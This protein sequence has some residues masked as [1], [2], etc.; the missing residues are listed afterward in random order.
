MEQ[1]LQNIENSL[2]HIHP[3]PVCCW[4]LFCDC[5]VINL[6][7]SQPFEK[8][9]CFIYRG[10]CFYDLLW[11]IFHPGIFFPPQP[12]FIGM[13]RV[14]AT[15][16]LSNF[17]L[18]SN[19]GVILLAFVLFDSCLSIHVGFLAIRF[20]RYKIFSVVVLALR[21]L[22]VVYYLYHH[23]SG[24]VPARRYQQGEK[25][26][27]MSVSIGSQSRNNKRTI[28]Y[29]VIVTRLYALSALPTA[30]GLDWQQRWPVPGNSCT[31]IYGLK[32]G[33]QFITQSYFE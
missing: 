9:S 21:G 12:L 26:P 19:R 29:R 15:F 7:S 27:S 17:N 3:W 23:F 25:L 16:F 14:L 32:F 5:T 24:C 20:N 31:L 10:I 28:I 13:Q 30:N 18:I 11:W 4:S 6:H 2:R 22:L 33:L 8:Q 1:K